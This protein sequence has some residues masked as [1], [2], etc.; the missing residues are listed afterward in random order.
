MSFYVMQK[1][2]I[3]TPP[4]ELIRTQV[5][6]SLMEEKREQILNEHFQRMRVKADIKV[7]RLP[8]E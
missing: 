4:L 2:D 5:E 3:N 7:L 8:E 6:N 1:N